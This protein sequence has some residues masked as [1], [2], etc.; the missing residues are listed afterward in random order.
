MRRAIIP[1][2]VA[3]LG[4]GVFVSG[5]TAILYHNVFFYKADGYMSSET[6]M[7]VGLM[8]DEKAPLSSGLAFKKSGASS[9]AYR[10]GRVTAFIGRTNH[11]SIDLVAECERLGGCELRR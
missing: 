11:T 9:Y 4:T 7:R 2:V 6:A 5:L 3:A 10:E 8:K 1:T